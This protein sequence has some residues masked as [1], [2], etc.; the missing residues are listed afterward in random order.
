MLIIPPPG[1][2]RAKPGAPSLA[3]RSSPFEAA[4]LSRPPPS[5][6]PPSSRFPPSK[7]PPSIEAASFEGTGDGTHNTIF[8]QSLEFK[9]SV[10]RTLSAFYL[11][12]HGSCMSSRRAKGPSYTTEAAS[13][14]AFS[15]EAASEE[16]RT[17]AGFE[18]AHH[19]QTFETSNF[20]GLA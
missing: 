11:Y 4:A 5:Q 10:S 14:E 20:E 13:F 7:L 12:L 6:V 18:N 9:N 16:S 15:F 17:L 19:N 8:N 1:T 3:V 2:P